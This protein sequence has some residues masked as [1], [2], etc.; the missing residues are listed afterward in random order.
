MTVETKTFG[1]KTALIYP[2]RDQA[3]SAIVAA[4]LEK[5]SQ[6]LANQDRVDIALTGGTDGIAMLNVARA[7]MESQTNP[8]SRTDRTD[9][10]HAYAQA[11]AGP[12]SVGLILDSLDFSRI[13]FWWG[14]ER[15]VAADD[16]DRN[17]LQARDAWLDDLAAHHGLPEGNIHEMPAD[18][19]PEQTV[20]CEKDDADANLK[21]LVP[22]A[23]AYQDELLN[24]LGDKG[25]MDIALFSMGPDGHF[26]SLFPGY[27]QIF[28]DDDSHLVLPVVDSPKMPPLRLTLTASFIQGSSYVW[29]IVTGQRKAEA[30]VRALH[31]VNDEEVPSSFGQG[32]EET[33]WFLDRQAASKL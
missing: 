3:I 13:H 22:A 15:F 18:P 16:Q 21:A 7:L 33:M 25:H 14:D 8:E 30:A 6:L 4:L 1:P 5:T 28:D 19:R 32:T 26:A 20:I 17:A 11:P 23:S 2:D 31:T 29:F 10:C 9:D 12:D 27:P 24:Q